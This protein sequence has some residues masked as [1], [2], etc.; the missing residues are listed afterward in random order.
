MKFVGKQ[1]MSIRLKAYDGFYSS[2]SPIYAADKVENTSAC[3]ELAK[4]PKT[5]TG[6]GTNKGTSKHRTDTTISSA[7]MFPNKRKLSERGFVKSS[8]MLIGKKIGVGEIYLAKN[9][10]PFSLNP[11]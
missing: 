1:I 4:I 10:R 6:S 8:S 11:A 2:D 5:I 9:P 3:T 7:R